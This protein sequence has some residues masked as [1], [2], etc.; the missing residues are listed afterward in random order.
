[1][2]EQLELPFEDTGS[3]VLPCHKCH[4]TLPISAFARGSTGKKRW[5]RHVWCRNCVN[6][7]CRERR[8]EKR[9]QAMERSHNAP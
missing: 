7:Y 8:E 5:D 4:M 1:M 6:A 2:A 3:V 9:R